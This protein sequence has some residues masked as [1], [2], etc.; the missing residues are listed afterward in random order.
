MEKSEGA[1]WVQRWLGLLFVSKN[2]ILVILIDCIFVILI[3]WKKTTR[4]HIKHVSMS[5]QKSQI[6][7]YNI[8]KKIANVVITISEELSCLLLI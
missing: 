3:V 1:W 8:T 2:S 4:I 6:N 5:E 7:I